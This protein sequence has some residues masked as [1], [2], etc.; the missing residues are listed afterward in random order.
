MPR[1]NRYHLPGHVWHIT[2]RCHRKQF[3]LRFTRDRQAWIDW[4]YEARKRFGLCVLDYVVT[5]N[6]IHLLVHDQGTGEIASSMQLIAGR[7]A[8]T[9]NQ[10]K[11]R[12]GAFWEDR[13]HATAVDT[14]QHL[15]R[16]VVY[17][18]MNMVR[19]G[20]VRHPREWSAGG[21][22]EI[23]APPP[24][25]RVI[26]RDALAGALGMGGVEELAA[27][28]AE[29]ITAALGQ[30]AEGRREPE[31]SESVAVGRRA[32]VQ[33][34]KAELGHRARHRH[35]EESDEA[36]ILRE[37]HAPSWSHF[38]LDKG[39]PSQEIVELER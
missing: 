16:C 26:D 5:S 2:Q 14:G 23:Q 13:Y 4:L 12:H 27:T 17:I 25:Y 36:C 20:I 6:H 29:W 3:L 31:W 19:A 32:F 22:H 37:E 1:A 21:Y 18:D 9:Y 7:T 33:R 15:A 28:H 24:R 34:V 30:K 11:H 8:Q 35:L 38:T 10:R 39:L